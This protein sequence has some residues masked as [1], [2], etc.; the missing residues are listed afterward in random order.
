MSSHTNILY[1]NIKILPIYNF[2]H[3]Y[4]H[5]NLHVSLL[6]TKLVNHIF[7]FTVLLYVLEEHVLAPPKWMD[8]RKAYH[9]IALPYIRSSLP[10]CTHGLIPITSYISFNL[11]LLNNN[12][13]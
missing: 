5:F 8:S 12:T 1:F 13:K 3:I 2:I 11:P 7:Q 10:Y 6:L 9:H 4:H